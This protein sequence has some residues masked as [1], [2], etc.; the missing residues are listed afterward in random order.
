RPD[1]ACRAMGLAAWPPMPCGRMRPAVR[2]E[3][4]DPRETRINVRRDHVIS[5]NFPFLGFSVCLR[6]SLGRQYQVNIFSISREN[7]QAAEKL[8]YG[9]GCFAVGSSTKSL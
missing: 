6:L 3:I 9:S 8:S 1:G 2:E 7:H 5:S 4:A